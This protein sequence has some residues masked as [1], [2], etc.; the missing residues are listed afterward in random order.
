LSLQ[1]GRATIGAS[2]IGLP[3]GGVDSISEENKA[4][5]CRFI[6]EVFNGCNLAT[7]DE[8]IGP[9]WVDQVD[10]VS[11]EEAR[12]LEGARQFVEVYR[13]AFPDMHMIVE[14]QIAE[15]DKVE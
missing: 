1:P 5:A 4:L 3:G 6:E 2:H 7:I 8:L 14:D 11:F 13:S 15:G 10:P 9:D 12:S